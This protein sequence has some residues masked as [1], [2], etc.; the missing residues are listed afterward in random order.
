MTIELKDEVKDSSLWQT[1]CNVCL[2]MI[3]WP[4]YNG[5]TAALDVV[6]L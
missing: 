1:A 6:R 2:Q 4:M 5:G 3:S